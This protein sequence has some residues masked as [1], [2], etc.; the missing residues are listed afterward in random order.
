AAANP[1]LLSFVGSRQ[2]TRIV[3]TDARRLTRMKFQEEPG[4]ANLPIGGLQ[5]AI[6]ENGVSGHRERLT[7]SA[8]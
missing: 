6:Q 7:L 4:N 2:E 8:A 3:T 5:D 1:W